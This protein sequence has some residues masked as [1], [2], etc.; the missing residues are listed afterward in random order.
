LGQY[1]HDLDTGYGKPQHRFWFSP[2]L[3]YPLTAQIMVEEN[4]KEKQREIALADNNIKSLG[5]LIPAV[6]AK[7]GIGYDWQA[8][9][10]VVVN[11]EVAP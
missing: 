2:N 6:I 4:G 8:V 3:R 11:S 7:I 9:Q 10:E 1:I 5:E